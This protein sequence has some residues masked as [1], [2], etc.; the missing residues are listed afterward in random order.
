[1]QQLGWDPGS[2]YIG[3]KQLGYYDIPEIIW[4][5]YCKQG[6]KPGE[7]HGKAFDFN[8]KA[9][10]SRLLIPRPSSEFGLDKLEQLFQ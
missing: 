7:S 8:S 2:A 1:M 10:R 3:L 6:E 4:M 5:K 9:A